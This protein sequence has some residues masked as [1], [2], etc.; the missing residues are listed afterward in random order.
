MESVPEV[1]WF[2]YWTV[3]GVDPDGRTR[4]RWKWFHFNPHTG[5]WT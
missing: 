2:G 3:I 1:Y 4:M 5:R